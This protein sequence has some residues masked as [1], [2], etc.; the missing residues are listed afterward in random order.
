M[1][2]LTSN[3]RPAHAIHLMGEM[4]FVYQF[5][6]RAT[7]AGLRCIAS[8]TERRTVDHPDGSKTSEFCFVRFRN[9]ESWPIAWLP[10][11]L[12]IYFSLYLF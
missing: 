7:A 8:T 4:T 12:F 1:S 9:Y 6:Q 10:A 2:N 11:G 3:Q 5:V